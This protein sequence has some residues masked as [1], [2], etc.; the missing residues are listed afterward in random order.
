MAKIMPAQGTV[1]RS[2]IGGLLICLAIG[3]GLAGVAYF[4]LE[5][6]LPSFLLPP[7]CVAVWLGSAYALLV[8]GYG[9]VR[10]PYGSKGVA[11][12]G[13]NNPTGVVLEEGDH[14][15][16]F[17]S[18]ALPV[19]M[20]NI[21]IDLSEKFTATAAN[22]NPV[23]VD[24]FLLGSVE[25]PAKWL[26]TDNAKE[27]L[28][29]VLEARIRFFTAVVKDALSAIIF[30]DLLADYLDLAPRPTDTRT[31]EHQ[32]VYDSLMALATANEKYVVG[33]PQSVEDLMRKETAG[34][35]KKIAGEFGFRILQVE[36]EEFG[37]PPEIKDANLRKAAAQAEM[38]AEIIENDA[39]AAMVRKLKRAGVN[40]DVAMAAVNMQLGM[41]VTEKIKKWTITDIDKV[42]ASLGP[43][44]AALLTAF[45]TRPPQPP[46]TP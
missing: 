28:R 12:R 39:R 46:S 3:V 35:L 24:A 11:V 9:S 30:K 25:D 14:F 27:S 4:A 1:G 13:G 20:R 38:E 31:P 6:W 23:G 33:G 36:I 16:L 15:A 26:R 2:F 22:T 45:L 32:R 10:I 40:P 5:P 44:V 8:A 21:R 18:G 43:A 37:I 7:I 29:E 17:A 42:A 19:D 34:L 41:P